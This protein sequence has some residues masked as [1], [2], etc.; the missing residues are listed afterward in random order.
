[1]SHKIGLIDALIAACA[2]GH[3]FILCTFNTKHYRVIPG[4]N[5]AQPYSR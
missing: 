3:G 2:I 4:L 1:M 5:M